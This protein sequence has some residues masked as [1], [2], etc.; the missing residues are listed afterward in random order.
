MIVCPNCGEDMDEVIISGIKIDYCRKGCRGIWFDNYELDK[1]DE[2]TE[3]SG[4]VLAEILADPLK[5]VYRS[6]KLTCPKCNIFMRKRK[7]GPGV[8]I[9]IDNCYSCNSIFLDSG[10]LAAIRKNYKLIQEASQQMVAAGEVE[11]MKIREKERAE[12]ERR[13]R[14]RS[15]AFLFISRWF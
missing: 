15:R 4:P 5:N 14:G 11:L 3:G 6:E 10:E 8:D 7:F 2:E 1:L 9:D 13:Q 12:E